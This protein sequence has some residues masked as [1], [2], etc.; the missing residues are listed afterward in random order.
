M[1]LGQRSDQPQADAMG[2]KSVLSA[3]NVSVGLEEIILDQ[4]CV[5]QQCLT[6]VEKGEHHHRGH[7]SAGAEDGQARESSRYVNSNR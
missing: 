7:G 5:C 2:G 4:G 3:G 6:L 1:Q